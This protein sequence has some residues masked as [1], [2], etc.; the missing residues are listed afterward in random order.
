MIHSRTMVTVTCGQC[1]RNVTSA[2][3][4]FGRLPKKQDG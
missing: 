3:S 1:G 2:D 4:Q